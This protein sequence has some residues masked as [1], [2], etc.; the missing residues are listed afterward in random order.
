[1]VIRQSLLTKS[2]LNLLAKTDL[3]VSNLTN[4]KQLRLLDIK[5]Y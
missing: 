1:M 2:L 3:W 4:E 5:I